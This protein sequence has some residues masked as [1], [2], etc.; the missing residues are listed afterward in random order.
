MKPNGGPVFPT[1]RG[2]FTTDGKMLSADWMPG[3]TLRDW[4]AGQAMAA[5][6]GDVTTFMRATTVIHGE[7]C[8]S[9]APGARVV[10]KLAYELAD[11]MLAERG[12]E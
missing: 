11:A 8:D 5:L 3:M 4:F 12:E 7:P 10:V 1:S 6:V 9:A 2:H